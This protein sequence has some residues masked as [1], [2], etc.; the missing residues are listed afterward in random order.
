MY[1]TFLLWLLFPSDYTISE[2]DSK[3]YVLSIASFPLGGNLSQK[4]QLK[5]NKCEFFSQTCTVSL[6][7][8]SS[9]SS[10]FLQDKLLKKAAVGSTVCKESISISHSSTQFCQC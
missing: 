7:K 6:T 1:G 9:E 2:P 3:F 4:L 10:P 8:R 5:G